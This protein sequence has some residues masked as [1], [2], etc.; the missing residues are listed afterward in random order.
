MLLPLQRPQG[1]VLPPL[2]T[3]TILSVQEDQFSIVIYHKNGLRLGHGGHTVHHDTVH[4]VTANPPS[5]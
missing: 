5:V 4:F 3:S 2:P 1:Y